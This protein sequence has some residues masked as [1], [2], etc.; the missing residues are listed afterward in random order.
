MNKITL[1]LL[2]I[3][4]SLYLRAVVIS[5]LNVYEMVVHFNTLHVQAKSFQ[6]RENGSI[7][8]VVCVFVVVFKMV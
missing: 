5:A 7:N 1:L 3:T 2:C 4:I 6:H 8:D